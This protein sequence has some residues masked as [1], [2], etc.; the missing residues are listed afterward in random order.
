MRRE[1][2]LEA[3]T[4][5]TI[6]Y[7]LKNGQVEKRIVHSHNGRRLRGEDRPPGHFS[8]TLL[9]AYYQVECE[10]GSRFRSTYS[11]DRIKR[12]H[13]T[14]IQRWEQTGAAT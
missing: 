8:E 5:V 6:S 2:R 1:H 7:R 13:E 3:A 14:A 4:D 12:T 9:R 10:A 11:K